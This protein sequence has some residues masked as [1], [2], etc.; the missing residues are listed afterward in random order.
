MH[1]GIEKEEEDDTTNQGDGVSVDDD[2]LIDDDSW[3][4]ISLVSI[5]GRILAAPKIEDEDWGRTTIFQTL[6]VY[7]LKAKNLSSTEEVAWM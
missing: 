7:G 2:D 6:I 4:D 1:I 5:V 3:V